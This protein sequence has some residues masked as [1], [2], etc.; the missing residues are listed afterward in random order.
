MLGLLEGK[1]DAADER[2]AAWGLAGGSREFRGNVAAGG[3]PHGV[4][5]IG[6]HAVICVAMA[7]LRF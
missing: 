6:G 1:F 7:D 5:N 4:G 2:F 3:E